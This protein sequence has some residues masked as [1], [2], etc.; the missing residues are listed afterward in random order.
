MLI[1][2]YPGVDRNDSEKLLT[3]LEALRHV[4][5]QWLQVVSQLNFC[6]KLREMVKIRRTYL[7]VAAY[8]RQP[9]LLVRL[10]FLRRLLVGLGMFR[11]DTARLQQ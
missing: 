4:L 5:Q 6:R 1:A 9:G 8:F 10:A 2:F 3:L 11:L 7:L